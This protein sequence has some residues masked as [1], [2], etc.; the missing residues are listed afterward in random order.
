MSSRHDYRS[1]DAS[2]K[3]QTR[4]ATATSDSGRNLSDG[5]DAGAGNRKRKRGEDT[6][7]D[8]LKDSF[9]VRVSNYC[10]YCSQVF[11]LTICQPY[12]P[13][14]PN[15][16]HTL[17]P[18]VLLPRSQLSL[19]SLDFFC[20]SN[21]LPQSRLFETHVKVLELEERM[22]TQPMV[23]IAR[24]DDGRSLYAVEREDRGLYAICKLGSWV[25]LQQLKMV[26]A[27]A[28]STLPESVSRRF[29]LSS[30]PQSG[31]TIQTGT[32]STKFSKKK[33]LAIEAIQSMVKRPTTD[34]LPNTEL[35]QSS[36]SIREVMFQT[37]EVVDEEPLV[38]SSQQPLIENEP[39]AVP[40]ATEI[41]DNVRSQYFDALYLSKVSY[42]ALYHDFNADIFRLLWHTL[43]RALC[44]EHARRFI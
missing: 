24:L 34:L 35:T 40:T 5:L 18:L 39:S 21:A 1:T 33:R 32:T 19:S 7:E 17:Q 43:Q 31:T 16:T 44:L 9:V 30:V 42:T 3:D 11:N 22:G 10:P 28:V 12:P 14:P 27:A 13:K 8:L 36:T 26:A 4:P 41:F 25:N 6:A 29:D 37:P 15:K 23:L 38:P 20:T 2:A